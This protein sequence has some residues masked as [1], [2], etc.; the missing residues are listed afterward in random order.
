MALSEHD[1]ELTFMIKLWTA[2]F[3]ITKVA[4]SDYQ[5]SSEIN[6]LVVA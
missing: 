4:Q 3:L 5:G 6:S 2:C 1:Q